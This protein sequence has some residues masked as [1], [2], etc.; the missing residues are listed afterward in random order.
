MS[1]CT[2][3]PVEKDC[4]YPYKPTDCVHQRKF[5]SADHRA[6]HDPGFT[7][8]NRVKKMSATLKVIKGGK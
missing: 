8:P 1:D 7:L 2:F 3:C 5:W 4:F 6:I